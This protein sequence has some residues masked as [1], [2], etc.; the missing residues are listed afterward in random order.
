MQQRRKCGN[1]HHLPKKRKRRQSV[2]ATVREHR[3]PSTVARP[4]ELVERA[5]L[6]LHE[7][8]PI[9]SNENTIYTLFYE[10]YRGYTIYSTL[11]GRCC[12]HSKQGCIKLR[13]KFACFP[14]IEEAKTLIKRFR[15]EGYT[16][17]DSVER[18]LPEWEFVCLNWRE[19]Q[20][21]TPMSSRSMRAYRKRRS[22]EGRLPHLPL[23][24]RRCI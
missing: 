8:D 4:V 18:Y 15:A 12:I 2:P 22:Q 24:L 11:D 19:Q 6:T 1:P 7:T 17:S 10:Y 9:T 13:G 21:R 14:D 3:A 16:S 5:R 20:Q 23:L